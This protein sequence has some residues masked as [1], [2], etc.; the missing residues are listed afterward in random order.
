MRDPDL[1]ID[2][3]A[4]APWAGARGEYFGRVLEAVADGQRFLAPRRRGSKLKKAEQK[5]VLY[6]TGTKKVHVQYRNRYGRVRS[7]DTHYEGVVPWLH[8]PPRRGRVRPRP[9]DRS[10]A[11]CGR[12]PARSAAGPGSSRR[13]WPSP[14]AGRNIFELCDLSLRD[15]TAADAAPGAVASGTT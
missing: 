14:S 10:R 13:A 4:I 12:C 11:T 9:G 15:A 3:G 1:S 2:D 7:Y 5:V 6:G 8:P